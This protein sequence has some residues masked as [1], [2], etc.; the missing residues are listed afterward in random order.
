MLRE[1]ELRRSRSSG[2]IYSESSEDVGSD[3]DLGQRDGKRYRLM[4]VAN[5]LPVSATRAADGVWSLRDSV[6][7]LVAGLRGAEKN[8]DVTWIGW[9]GV[10]VETDSDKVALTEALVSQ[11]Y[12]PVFLDESLVEL[13]Y[14]GY[15]NSVLWQLFHYVSL[16]LETRLDGTQ[17]MKHQWNAY[18]Q[19]NVKFAE[20]VLK[21]YREGDIV[22]CHD[23]HL[24]LLPSLLKD[25]V[26]GM[27]V[28]WF[29]H[30]PFPSSEIYRTLPQREAVLR[31]VLSADLV[32]FH[33][34]DY[35]RHFV[36]AC[37]RIMGLEGTPEGVEDR[38]S[39][40]RV[41]A[42][43]IGIDPDHFTNAL[44][45]PEVRKQIDTLKARF[46]GK[47]VMLGVD[48][49][50]M[51]KGIPQKL[52]AFEKFLLERPQWRDQVLLVQIAVPTRKD[53][54]EYQKLRSL[55]HEIVGRINGRFGT[56]GSVPIHHLDREM[57]LQELCALYAVTDVAL[58]T[59][60][61]DGMNLV[62]YEF[63]ACQSE[64]TG[65]LVLSEFAGAAQSLGAGAILVNPWNIGEMALAI[66]EALSMPEKEKQERHQQNFK[67][68][69]AH[70]SS[71]WADN[72]I[73]EL[74][75]THVEAE[76]RRL[77]IPPMLSISAVCHAFA[78]AEFRLLVFGFNATLTQRI[79][80]SGPVAKRQCD[81][82]RE[83]KKVSPEVKAFLRRL[84][85]NSK[86]MIVIF[87]GSE[88]SRLEEVF[89]DLPIWLSA[90][91]GVFIRAPC[92]HPSADDADAMA[93][94]KQVIASNS[95]MALEVDS[96][97]SDTGSCDASGFGANTAAD[98]SHIEASGEEKASA[99]AEEQALTGWCT[100]VENAYNM[101][102]LES[103]QLVFDYFCERT[104][105]SFVEARETSLVWNYRYA[106]AEFGRLQARDMLQHLWT[107]PISNAA[108]DIVQGAKSVEVRPVGVS[109]GAAIERIMS[110]ME[111]ERKV[112]N[113]RKAFVLCV[114]HFLGRDEDLFTYFESKCDGKRNGGTQGALRSD[115]LSRRSY[116]SY[117]I[118]QD[119]IVEGEVAHAMSE[120]R[121]STEDLTSA[122][123][124]NRSTSSQKD[125][126]QSGDEDANDAASFFCSSNSLFT[127]TVGRKRSQARFYLDD[128]DAVHYMLKQLV[129]VV[130]LE[131]ERQQSGVQSRSESN[132]TSLRM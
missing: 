131:E 85:E 44:R 66:E 116:S 46:A 27:K 77:K 11:R 98:K 25:R 118:R 12:H 36:S 107:G 16:P 110:S 21:L 14:N 54:P 32:G 2:L 13:Y 108:V 22:W 45:D 109:K 84:A 88:R 23:Y 3:V 103:V 121:E 87:S 63:V 28:G 68:I 26:P 119:I 95:S 7:G 42:F 97:A 53:V 125:D 75:D 24:M 128:S 10:H 67:H 73:S 96:T 33:T 41:A 49:L 1:R 81:H 40:T 123:D 104:P 30:T 62:S 18:M 69:T 92:G 71:L 132:L 58:I 47:K 70:T 127:C 17:T 79:E 115:E 31:G 55:V 60:L 78:K 129:A 90:E 105:R 114:G 126:V 117:D 124:L 50:D 83:V 106:D 59:S 43:P 99:P 72:F 48:R 65:V 57:G 89:G 52:L 122:F 82:A 15:C 94:I 91:N 9:P 19:A 35:A 8:Y 4:I 61:R 100:T 20:E 86:T 37:T 101:D 111:V 130:Q 102:W 5:R 80:K 74:N 56:I 113:S 34:Y 29:L 64:K 112:S 38:G 51:I 93:A 39:A 6:S 76:L 120:P